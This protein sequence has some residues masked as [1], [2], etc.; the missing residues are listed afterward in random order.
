MERKEKPVDCLLTP[1][2]IRL[3]DPKGP[4]LVCS[5]CSNRSDE[6]GNLAEKC[7]AGKR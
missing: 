6:V 5:R 4:V 1:E 3:A 7:L 2:A